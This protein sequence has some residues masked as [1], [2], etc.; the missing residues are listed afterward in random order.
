MDIKE[1]AE[2]HTNAGIRL[3]MNV[4]LTALKDARDAK[5]D[6]TVHQLISLFEE[7]VEKGLTHD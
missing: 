4:A 3:G 6:V 1:L 2:N 7:I 5:E